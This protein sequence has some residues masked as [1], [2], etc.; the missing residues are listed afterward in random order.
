[1]SYSKFYI[2]L[3]IGLLFVSGFSQ[4]VASAVAANTFQQPITF[5]S[6]PFCGLLD[7]AVG[8]PIKNTGTAPL[9]GVVIGVFHNSIGQP[10]E[11]ATGVFYNITAQN[12]TTYVA[13]SL[14]SGNYSINFF[15]WS[16]NGSSISNTE[17]VWIA[18]T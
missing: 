16:L 17:T 18:C 7:G 13:A 11:I 8:V 3:G 15:V 4:V 14:P 6:S 12:F 5:P 9:S 10:L 2:V 1:M